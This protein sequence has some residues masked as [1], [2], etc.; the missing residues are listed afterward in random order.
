VHTAYAVVGKVPEVLDKSSNS[1]IFKAGAAKGRPL[2]C[3]SESGGHVG[4]RENCPPGFLPGGSF[5]MG[6]KLMATPPKRL[7]KP[8]DERYERGPR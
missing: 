1:F 7:P 8:E 5:N 6:V 4:A 2:F 3:R